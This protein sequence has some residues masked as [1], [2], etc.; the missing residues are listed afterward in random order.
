MG[1]KSWAPTKEITFSWQMLQDRILF[2]EILIRCSVLFILVVQC[3]FYALIMWS[4]FII[5]FHSIGLL[6]L[7][8]LESIGG[9]VVLWPYLSWSLV[10]SRGGGVG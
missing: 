7:S 1:G 5:C 9:M 4:Q 6:H 3:D 2:R 8:S 10:C